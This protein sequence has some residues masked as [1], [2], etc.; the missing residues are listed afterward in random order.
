MG[1]SAPREI[2]EETNEG[3]TLRRV[4]FKLEASQIGYSIF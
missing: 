4:I 1:H 3:L 2:N